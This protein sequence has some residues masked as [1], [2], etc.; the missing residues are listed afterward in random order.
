MIEH[1][2]KRDDEKCLDMLEKWL[3]VDVKASYCK[4]I[5]AL[6]EHHLNR[7]VEQVENEVYKP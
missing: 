4:L 3:E 6:Q 1:A 7:A 2:N 5:N